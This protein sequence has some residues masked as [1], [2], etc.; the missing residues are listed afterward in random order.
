MNGQR[1]LFIRILKNFRF[2]SFWKVS[3]SQLCAAFLFIASSLPCSIVYA[4]PDLYEEAA[5]GNW[6]EVIVQLQL[7]DLSGLDLN[8]APAGRPTLGEL[9][10]KAP[11]DVESL[12]RDL[13]DDTG[14]PPLK[15][16]RSLSPQ[17]EQEPGPVQSWEGRIFLDAV[18]AEVLLPRLDIADVLSLSALNRRMD[19]AYKY[20]LRGENGANIRLK[21]RFF[22]LFSFIIGRDCRKDYDPNTVKSPLK[23]ICTYMKNCESIGS[24]VRFPLGCDACARPF[25]RAKAPFLYSGTCMTIPCLY[26]WLKDQLNTMISVYPPETQKRI[27]RIILRK[28]IYTY[29]ELR[30]RN[31]KDQWKS[32]VF[33]FS[34]YEPSESQPLA[35]YQSLTSEILAL[36]LLLPEGVLSE[37]ETPWIVEGVCEPFPFYPSADM[38]DD[39]DLF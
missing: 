39:E 9:F 7:C 18:L 33:A 17:R 22:A 26:G 12:I 23:L 11:S 30:K 5:V 35:I 15:R 34:A 16:S 37:V 3:L 36:D 21:K 31:H 28:F 4:N 25:G 13:L 19:N 8:Y 6:D 2:Q 20:D 32:R 1:A 10:S 27:E 29:S 38:D 24:I 14:S